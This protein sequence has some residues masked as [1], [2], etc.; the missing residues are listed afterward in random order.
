MCVCASMN[1]GRT[2]ACERSISA[3]SA[4]GVPFGVTETILLRSITISAF[5]IGASLLPSINLPARIAMRC[6]ACGYANIG[7]RMSKNK[8]SSRRGI[9][10]S[11][12][13]DWRAHSPLC[14]PILQVR[15]RREVPEPVA[16]ETERKGAFLHVYIY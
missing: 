1:P 11:K 8:K 5:R 15:P 9:G 3:A 6:G 2:V 10:S 4:G 14:D 13:V 16:D 7:N 12:G